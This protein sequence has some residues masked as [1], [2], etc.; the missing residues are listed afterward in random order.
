METAAKALASVQE[1]LKLFEERLGL[2]FIKS[3][4]EHGLPW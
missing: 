4:S 1:D 3:S 2:T